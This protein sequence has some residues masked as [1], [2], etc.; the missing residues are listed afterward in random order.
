MSVTT[1]VPFKLAVICGGPSPERGISLNSARSVMDHLGGPSVEIIP[2]FVDWRKQF[3]LISP[4]QLYSNTPA[5]FDFKLNRSK[6]LLDE[7]ALK[8][9]LKDVDLVFPVI[10]GAFGEDGE[11]QELL[12]SFGVPFIGHSSLSCKKMFNKYLA[13]EFMR[14]HGFPIL[15]QIRLLPENK[16]SL[17]KLVR[18]FF[19]Q[20]QLRRAVVK[21]TLGGSSINVYS[22]SNS[23]EA[24]ER[25]ESIFSNNSCKEVLL[26]TF[27]TGKEFTVVMFANAKGDPVALIPTEI[28]LSYANNQIFD[29][30]KKYL[31]SNQA[32]YHTPPRFPL[33]TVKQI[34]SQ[35]EELY[36][37]FEM[38]DFVRLDGWL[39]EKGMLYFTDIN[40]ISGLEQNSFLFRQ[41]AILGMTHRKTLEYLIKN[42][43]RRQGLH[44]FHKP[45][46]AESIPKMP[47]YV[48]YGNNNAERQVSLMS[49][50]N[51]WLKLL[52]SENY[53][54]SPF[55]FDPEGKIW[56][57]PYAYNLN[58]TVEEI[59]SNCTSENDY[60]EQWNDLLKDICNRLEI[61]L[62]PKPPSK[63]MNQH[64]F[65]RQAQE[66]K[67]FVFIAMHGG[68]GENGTIQSALERYQ[69]PYNGSNSIASALCMDKL[70]TGDTIAS[71]K[72]PDLLTLPKKNLNFVDF[73][74]NSLEDW[75]AY[76]KTWTK[77]LQTHQLI[78][79]PRFDGCSAG[80]ALLE[81]AK[82]LWTYSCLL[83]EKS[84]TIPPHTFTKQEN[85][86]EMPSSLSGDFILEPYIETDEMN[87]KQGE[88]QHLSK[89]GWIEL[90]IGILEQRNIYY[91]LNPSIT[92]AE[93]AVLSVEEKFQ[94]GT[95]INLTPPPEEII[96][97]GAVQ[98][99]KRLAIKAAQALGIQNYARLD[100]FFNRFSEKMIVIEANTLPALT[101]ST[102]IYHQ[103][104]AENPPLSPLKLLEKIICSKY[105]E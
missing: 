40:P 105:L 12:E 4:A 22:V 87:I 29:Y 36:R 43:C 35:A 101:P 78:I 2:L 6:D 42:S 97:D 89:Q 7:A 21:P 93:G 85:P 45:V 14:A 38:Q 71:I 103:G 16:A 77:N 58:H 79:K 92:L 37:L 57:L 76:W 70:L 27:C 55:L 59:C 11:L 60:N 95:G 65:F 33:S 74:N 51:V 23:E 96:S 100:I 18:D 47:V 20:H 26:E 99:I 66:K 46:F 91:A 48:L 15:P 41:S 9:L 75:E 52:Q 82:D 3:Y 25:I 86:I 73:Q 5:D 28:D 90:T 10:H 31:P 49:G 69:I 80:I 8:K 19:E 30:R 44:F 50:T 53:A 104:L 64:D 39:T 68:E 56:E 84:S 24:C 13:A 17:A 1:S 54:P 94:G 102:V 88:I 81:S 67:A 34:C 62:Q 98:K 61:P 72:D 83:R 63:Q 32:T